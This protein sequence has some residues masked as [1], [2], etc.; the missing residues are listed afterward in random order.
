MLLKLTLLPFNVVEP[1]S[2]FPSFFEE[3]ETMT[4]KHG[5]AIRVVCI[6]W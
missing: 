4:E 6:L 5:K 1:K 3:L 2:D